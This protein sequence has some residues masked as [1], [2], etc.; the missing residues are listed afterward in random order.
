MV[1]PTSSA[2]NR[3]RSAARATFGN[4]WPPRET[5]AFSLQTLETAWQI[6][7]FPLGR[8]TLDR[9]LGV[10]ADAIS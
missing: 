3:L 1:S 9:P 5:G 6:Q 4:P 10:R 7:R 8:D 2:T